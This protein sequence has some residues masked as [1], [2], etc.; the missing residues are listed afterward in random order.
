MSEHPFKL[1]R[2]REESPGACARMARTNREVYGAVNPNCETY[3][4][5]S[6]ITIAVKIRST[7]NA[8][9]PIGWVR[10][11]NESSVMISV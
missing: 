3:K 9:M 10:K 1:D 8:I 11:N 6:N 2:Y 4:L 7:M 5:G